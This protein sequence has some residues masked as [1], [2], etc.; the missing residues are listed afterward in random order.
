MVYILRVQ[1]GFNWQPSQ[2]GFIALVYN[3]GNQNVLIT[4]WYA[5]LRVLS[6]QL[7]VWNLCTLKFIGL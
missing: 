5:F 6:K 7:Y 1:V 3:S 2:H 4:G